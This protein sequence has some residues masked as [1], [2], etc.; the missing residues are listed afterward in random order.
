LSAVN[1][2]KLWEKLLQ[3]IASLPRHDSEVLSNLNV[4]LSSGVESRRKGTVSATVN[5]WNNTFGKQSSLS[6]PARLRTAL[7]K[8]KTVADILLPSFPEDDTVR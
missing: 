8:L 2:T 5:L 4:L 1:A 6:Y 3:A 7:A